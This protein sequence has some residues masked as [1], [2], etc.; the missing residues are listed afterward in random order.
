M[1]VTVLPLLSADMSPFE[2]LVDR[3]SEPIGLSSQF[4]KPY[5]AQDILKSLTQDP[6]VATDIPGMV[7]LVNEC[8]IASTF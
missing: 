8:F 2:G 3:P 6:R 7:R 1:V 4:Y 5:F